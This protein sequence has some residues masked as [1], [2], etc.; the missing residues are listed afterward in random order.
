[1]SL[2]SAGPSQPRPR[3]ATV[4]PATRA[5]KL[6]RTLRP[7]V[8]ITEPSPDIVVDRDVEV[9]SRDGVVLRV[10]V[11][12]PP[13]SGEF[14][15]LLCIHPY[16]KDNLPKR[17]RNGRYSIPFQYRLLSQD[18]PVTHSAYAG[19][20]APD[21]AHWVARGYAVINADLR[22]WGHSD[23]VGSVLTAQD[24]LDGH[25][26]VEWIAAQPWSNGNV[27]MSGVSY[28][29]ITQWRTAATRPPHL[30][31]I[32][33]WEG[34]TDAYRDF[35]MPGGIRENGFS[36]IWDRALSMS[37]GNRV[38]LRRGTKRRP[39]IDE[40]WR[41]LNPDLEQIQVPAL[42]CGSFSDHSLHTRGS[43]AAFGR[44]ASTR[45]WLYT[46]R[47]P[48]W[49]TYYSPQALAVQAR[50]FDHFLRGDDTGILDEP[51]V[52]LEVRSDAHTVAE[53]S[54]EQQW[55]PSDVRAETLYADAIRGRLDA[56]PPT[57]PGRAE[58]HRGQ[59]RFCWRFDEQTD[60]VGPMRAR[61]F[62]STDAADMKL[63]VG[64]RKFRDDREIGFEGSYGLNHD[65]V[66]HGWLR[67]SH[68]AVDPARSTLWEP[69]HPHTSVQPL[70]RGGV[71]ELDI[72]L[73][74]SATRFEPGEQLVLE[75]RD[76]WF[77]ALNPLSGS[78]P[79]HYARRRPSRWSA[80]TG[81]Y[82]P[83]SLTIPVRPVADSGI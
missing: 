66:T 74:P 56:A 68:R 39:L 45:K 38:G 55:P 51:P 50:F 3:P 18:E 79:A 12:R 52:R 80:H 41:S 32:N 1:M 35:L 5:D 9:T 61:V 70:E 6:R 44:I 23:G 77:F 31:A 42:I 36:I 69:F 33:P 76:S 24:G 7:L 63:F 27:G 25:D 83:T 47:G 54:G 34:F 26:V 64:V 2:R 53:V 13:G 81:G 30:K 49:S 57:L 16:G 43:F 58:S 17:K 73:L 62:V 10:N 75:I 67:A 19:W 20:E 65:V 71:Y 40:W 28:L 48:K 14:P 37:G 11:Y 82:S 60:V 72:A 78:F 22:G 59:V 46:H 15:A 29:A 8:T 21:P 4:G